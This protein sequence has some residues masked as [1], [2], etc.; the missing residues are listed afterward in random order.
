MA[1]RE[2]ER[3]Q[4]AAELEKNIADFVAQLKPK[5]YEEGWP[6]DKWE[7]EMEKHPLFMTKP[8]ED[9]QELPPEVEALQQ[10]KYDPDEN[11]PEELAKSYKDDGNRNFKV[12]KYRWAVDSYTQGLECECTDTE[13]NAQLYSNR[14]AAHFHIGNYQK[15]LKDATQAKIL[16]PDYLKA[17]HH[18]AQC[19]YQ[20]ERF[21]DCIMWC[22]EGLK[23]EAKNIQLENLKAKSIKA[24]KLAD[25]N[26]RKAAAKEGKKKKELVQLLNSIRGQ[27]INFDVN[28]IDLETFE[29]SLPH[30]SGY[31]VH[32]D[33]KGSLVWPVLLL[34][35]E[36][37]VSDSILH[38]QEDSSFME[39]LSMIFTPEDIPSWDVE[40]K[41]H[42]NAL[43]VY[44]G[45]HDDGRL[46][47]VP[48]DLPLKTILCDNR[49]MVRGGIPS[50][51]VTVKDSKFDKIFRKNNGMA[52]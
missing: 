37:Q 34:Y 24:K 25:R 30:L 9:G 28:S 10:L 49:C 16:K 50:F 43:Q 44:F 45:H 12:K 33:D 36:Y 40:Q 26:K 22:D 1:S 27:G 13:L 3:S 29:P 52:T 5:K 42:L 8:L 18:G 39:Q 20:M 21:E 47:E 46:I 23:V 31:R 15:A 19:C 14:A 51:F 41:Y 38:F 2:E 4:L 6:E 48:K 32:F 17:I 35:P 11:T 7:Q